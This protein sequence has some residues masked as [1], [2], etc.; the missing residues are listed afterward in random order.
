[1]ASLIDLE[2]Q[3]V[4]RQLQ[5][6]P[7]WVAWR[8]ETRADGDGRI[9]LTKVPYSPGSQQKASVTS[10][11][12]W[13]SF[14]DAV[15]SL[16]AGE[17][18][19]IGFVFT[20]ED[21]YAGIDLEKCRDPATGAVA[22]WAKEIIAQLDS[23]TEVSPSGTGLHVI[24]RA[25]LPAGG[26]RKGQIEMY[27]RDRFFCMT[28]RIADGLPTTIAERQSEIEDLHAKTFGL[29][30]PNPQEPSRPQS[31]RAT[32]QPL[33]DDIVLDKARQARNGDRFRRLFDDGDL[34]GY[35]SQ[36]EAD[37]AL[38]AHLVYW[39]NN[40]PVQMDRLFRRSSLMRPKW[41]ERHAADGRTYGAITIE[42]AVMGT[43][44]KGVSVRLDPS[45]SGSHLDDQRPITD[46]AGSVDTE[47]DTKDFH[48]SDTGNATLF[49]RMHGQ[50]VRFDFRRN[51]WFVWTG[52]HWARDQDG[53]LLR[54]AEL[55]ARQRYEAAWSLP[56]KEDAKRA[57]KFAIETENRTRVAAMLD[58]ARAREPIADSGE[59]WDPDPMLLGVPNGVVDLRDGELRDGRRED[60]VSLVA[61][62]AY[63][64]KAVANRWLRFLY[65]IFNGK[66]DL[67]DF[68]Q[69]AVGY[70]LTG[71]VSEQCLFVLHGTGAN[72]K[73]TFLNALRHVVGDYGYNMPFSTVEMDQRSSVPNDLAALVGRR[74]V[75]SS[76]TNEAMRL[77]E[78]R[79]K[80]LTGG[81]PITARFLHREFFTFH[82][83]ATFWLAVNHKPRVTD[84]SHGFWR[85][86][87]LIP[88]TQQFPGDKTLE[89]QLRGEAPAI[90]QWAV[91]GCLL[92]Q[93]RGLDPPDCVLSATEEYRRESDLLEEFIAEWIEDS[94]EATTVPIREIAEAYEKWADREGL[95]GRERLGS[96]SLRSRLKA[97]WPTRHR[98]AVRRTPAHYVGLQLRGSDA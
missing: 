75:T 66:E 41:I 5:E 60:H 72:G 54:L 13:A 80:A 78:G 2:I 17:C 14:E 88:F 29:G 15:Q 76:E 64:P 10:P 4:P 49:S 96:R 18:N 11:S 74:L 77:N 69:R 3:A 95:K 26:R 90:L 16:E 50:D 81:D 46:E 62:V 59:S 91:Q 63:D 31:E 37:L 43:H 98:P 1:M 21:P 24:V 8:A 12:T 47:G 32:A 85:R 93:Q 39:T 38:C 86:V 20:A 9:K 82:P 45:S 48:L 28:G 44:A 70:S 97:R 36:S 79:V 87:R 61:G 73:S 68:V 30:S 67:I 89:P 25:Q 35:P 94:D 40:D 52:H 84:D 53:K 6:G 51:S 58:L 56:D 65:E 33:D 42:R 19:G 22:A 23:Y 83:V 71:D 57:A 34:E 7:Q 55:V 27:D 92:W